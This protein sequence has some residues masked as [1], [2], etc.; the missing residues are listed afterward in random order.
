MS[1]GFIEDLL[2]EWYQFKGF[3]VHRGFTVPSENGEQPLKL[4]FVA[5]NLEQRSV[6]H[7]EVAG[8]ALSSGQIKRRYEHKFNLASNAL[9]AAFD[10]SRISLSLSQIL[11]TSGASSVDSEDIDT[12]DEVQAAPEFLKKVMEDLLK[13]REISEIPSHLS[14]LSALLSVAT[15]GSDWASRQRE[16]S[17]ARKREAYSRLD[18]GG[19]YAQAA[20]EVEPTMEEN[21][22]T[23]A[24]QRTV[25]LYRSLKFS[26][27]LFL[28]SIISALVISIVL[29][30]GI[31]LWPYGIVPVV[32][33]FLWD[34]IVISS[35]QIRSANSAME[36]MPITVAVG[37]YFIIW[38]PFAILCLP[39]YFVG[40]IGQYLADL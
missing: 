10:R 29:V 18:M 20:D 31:I 22:L 24:I 16:V 37:L 40:W 17:R 15:V 39:F 36:A 21:P 1:E 23:A 34:S 8:Y 28:P 27:A 7:V 19:Y 25:K 14:I 13:S 35:K 32:A 9:T 38:L 30:L 33:S 12:L 4:S 3:F 2:S 11:I 26:P 5:F 6:V